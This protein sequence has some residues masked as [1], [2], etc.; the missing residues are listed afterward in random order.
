MRAVYRVFAAVVSIVILLSFICSCG[1]KVRE[2]DNTNLKK[3]I[4]AIPENE[5][6]LLEAAARV[7]RYGE[8]CLPGRTVENVGTYLAEDCAILVRRL[9]FGEG[10]ETVTAHVADVYIDNMSQFVG[11]VCRDGNGDL[12]KKPASDAISD[13]NAVLL[14]NA[15]F[16]TA[17]SWG[18]YV[19]GGRT[20]RDKG[21]EGVDL[22]LIGKSGKM[23][24]CSG[25]GF[26]K[27]SALKDSDLYHIFSFGPSLLNDDGSPR[28]KD[29]EFH[30]TDKY[31]KWNNYE[32]SV[33]FPVPNPR[34]AIGQA[35]DGHF[36]FVTVDGRMKGYSRGAT[37]PE[38]SHILWE[39][40]A[41]VA[42][43]LDGGGSE[44][45]VFKGEELTRQYS[46]E[47]KRIPS[48]YICITSS[49]KASEKEKA[50]PG[51]N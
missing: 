22:C 43:N 15:D 2:P 34:T 49:G 36:I 42:Y 33:G 3:G 24:V 23:R 12:T 29:G 48:D 46:E 41:A 25:D 11:Y 51:G 39:E 6:E 27:K 14:I 13:T 45:M 10:K 21:T 35:E 31:S 17:R 26:N 9:T 38:M 20:I 4:C 30:I 7:K 5:E 18:L 1:K 8:S 37:F 32:S 50:A 40:G 16:L 19:R 44:I 28:D 47:S